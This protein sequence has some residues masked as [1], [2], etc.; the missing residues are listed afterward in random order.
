[1]PLTTKD[2]RHISSLLTAECKRRGW[3]PNRLGKEAGI[4]RDTARNTLWGHGQAKTIFRVARV[5]GV[6][7]GVEIEKDPPLVDMDDGEPRSYGPIGRHC[8]PSRVDLLAA[9][10]SLR[11]LSEVPD[12][13]FTG[14]GLLDDVARNLGLPADWAERDLAEFEP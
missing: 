7:V 11:R 9:R 1:M 14:N 4:H 10:Y 13:R 6:E 3:S 8:D 5:L 2:R 12:I